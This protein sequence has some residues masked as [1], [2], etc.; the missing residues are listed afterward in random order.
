MARRYLYV[1]LCGLLASFEGLVTVDGQD[2]RLPASGPPILFCPPPLKCCHGVCCDPLSLCIDTCGCF[3][4]VNQTLSSSPTTSACT[5]CKPMT[6]SI[7]AA[8]KLSGLYLDG[9]SLP[10]S[11]YPSPLPADA[12]RTPRNIP[13]PAASQVLAVKAESA[14]PGAAGV[15]ASV[16]DD[17]LLS[18]A[19]WKCSAASANNWYM[20]SFDD[21]LWSQAVVTDSNP[22]KLHPEPAV[23]GISNNA[24]WIW[25]AD[26]K[27]P[28][29]CRA[30]FPLPFPNPIPFPF[31]FNTC[32]KFYGNC[33]NL[34][35]LEGKTCCNCRMLNDGP[36]KVCNC[37][38][39]GYRC[40]PPV[41][42]R[43][44]YSC[45][46][47]DSTCSGDGVSCVRGTLP[48]APT[49]GPCGQIISVDPAAK[50]DTPV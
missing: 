14:S 47:L 32:S 24:S 45:C 49:Y 15:L 5:I 33:P 36:T 6:L 22:G 28:I 17:Y 34:C 2:A 10:I 25:T 13:I 48:P 50:A 37:C 46:P 21:S 7:T 42:P 44:T 18:G 3:N 8:D 9:V 41:P 29:Y 30:Y 40:C 16:N 19:D 27:S 1:V 39:S 43:F 20:P 12:W 23:D 38:P 4:F 11:P 31:P 26:N 35:A